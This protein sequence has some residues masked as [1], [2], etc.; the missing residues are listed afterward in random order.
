MGK[1]DFSIELCGGTHVKRLGDIGLFKIINETGIASGIRRI[2]AVTGFTAYQ[3]HKSKEKQILEIANILKADPSKVV[4]RISQIL[5]QQ[6]KLE[7]QIAT[8]QKQFA[9]NQ[10]DDLIKDVK[11]ING[12]NLLATR[13]EGVEVKDLRDIVDKLK[14]KLNKAIVILALTNNEKVS[15]VSGVTKNLTDIYHAGEILNHV[16]TQINGKG[17]GRADM[18]QGG[19]DNSK[20]LDE[21]LGTVKNLIL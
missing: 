5:D 7:K 15:L 16:A 4:N 6:K 17:G 21:V 18:A 19:G 2:E 11:E 14:D 9:G 10:V 8:F 13:I 1:D 20:K 12:V 3:F